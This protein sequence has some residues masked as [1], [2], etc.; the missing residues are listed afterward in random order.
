VFKEKGVTPEKNLAGALIAAILSDTLKFTSPTTTDEDKKAVEELNEVAGVNV[1]ELASEMFAA[2][3]DIS[4]V[5]TE[6]LL[7]K[8]YKVFEMSGKK[9]GIGV[10]ETVMPQTILERKAEILEKLAQ[11]KTAEGLDLIYFSGVDILNGNS[12]LFVVSEGEKQV[13]EAVWGSEVS[14]GILPL[15]G[16]V[17]RKKQIVPPLENYFSK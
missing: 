2:K 17:S 13:A 16:V 6:E 9:V 7:G 1:D 14:E 15:A 3:S 4:D 11:K 5:P 10:W 8:D 12:D